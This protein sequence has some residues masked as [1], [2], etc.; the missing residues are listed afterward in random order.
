MAKKQ[1]TITIPIHLAVLLAT[2]PEDVKE[3]QYENVQS[4]AKSMLR[5]LLASK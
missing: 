1:K 3:G 2:E 4:V 5:L